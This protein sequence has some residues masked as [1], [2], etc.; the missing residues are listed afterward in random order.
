MDSLEILHNKFDINIHKENFINY[1]EV[2]IR[3][4]GTIEYAVPSHQ[5]KLEKIAIEINGIEKFNQ[6]LESDEA[7]NDY[8]K[9]LCNFTGCVSVWNNFCV[10]PTNFT[11]EQKQSLK[12]LSE[13]YYKKIDLKLYQGEL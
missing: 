5:Q 2:I 9:W 13:N 4:D 11:N 7:Y 1:L 12:L 3:P 8:L 6:E 10:K